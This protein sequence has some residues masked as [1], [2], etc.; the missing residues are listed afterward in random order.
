M[1]GVKPGRGRWA[2]GCWV[3]VRV[4][5]LIF[6]MRHLEHFY[7]PM[8][9]NTAKR[10]MS[11]AVCASS[12]YSRLCMKMSSFLF[13]HA[14]AMPRM[15]YLLCGILCH[16]IQWTLT[17]QMCRLQS[18]ERCPSRWKWDIGTFWAWNWLFALVLAWRCWKLIVWT[19][20][21]GLWPSE[22]FNFHYYTF[23]CLDWIVWSVRS[24]PSYHLTVKKGNI[25]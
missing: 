23:V 8:K 20:F 21:C 14:C 17:E 10:N 3:M 18:E 6:I 2:L 7:L 11:S 4:K 16:K 13:V 19:G 1:Q 5:M 9:K 12:M 24:N 22:L 25:P 15:L